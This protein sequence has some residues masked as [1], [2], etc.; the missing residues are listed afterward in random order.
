MPK[1]VLSD[2]ENS[3]AS[4]AAIADALGNRHGIG[5]VVEEADETC[6]GLEL[7]RATRITT[8]PALERLLGEAGELNADLQ[9]VAADNEGECGRLCNAAAA[10]PSF[11]IRHNRTIP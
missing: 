10:A 4:Q 7:I 1:T 8:D 6:Y 5:R 3:A 9:P 2:V 11:R